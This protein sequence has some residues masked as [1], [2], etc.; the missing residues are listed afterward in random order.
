MDVVLTAIGIAVAIIMALVGFIA[1]G[2]RGDVKDT[3]VDVGKLHG[4]LDDVKDW[5]TQ[6]FVSK[7]VCE[8]KHGTA[9][10]AP[11]GGG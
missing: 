10:H 4:R 8:A 3:K 7:E 1:Y 11:V 6:T 2:I 5:S 9:R